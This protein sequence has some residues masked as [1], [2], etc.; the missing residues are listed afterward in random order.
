MSHPQYVKC[1]VCEAQMKVIPF[2]RQA[3][4]VDEFIN[5]DYPNWAACENNHVMARS[6]YEK[7]SQEIM[8]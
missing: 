1:S 8:K 6:E 4:S 2:A 5:K 3:E 7:L